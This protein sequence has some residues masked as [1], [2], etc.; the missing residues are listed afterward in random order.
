MHAVAM[1]IATVRLLNL[2]LPLPPCASMTDVPGP[3]ELSTL[4]TS[5]YNMGRGHIGEYIKRVQPSEPKEDFEDRLAIYTMRH[6]LVVS[7]L[8]PNWIHLRGV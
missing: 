1:G 7:G 6:D 4:N 8:W 3:V 2:A 5:R